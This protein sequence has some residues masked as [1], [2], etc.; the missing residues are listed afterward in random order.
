MLFDMKP[1]V[2]GVIALMAAI[3]FSAQAGAQ[4]Y[5]SATSSERPMVC[6][7]AGQ[8]YDHWVTIHELMGMPDR[9]ATI[10]YRVKLDPSEVALPYEKFQ[11][12]DDIMLV[13]QF[14]EEVDG[15]G[16]LPDILAGRFDESLRRLFELMRERGQPVALRIGP[17]ANSYWK[18]V[19][20]YRGQNRPWMY[21]EAFAKIGELFLEVAGPEMLRFVDWN[22]NQTSF[23]MDSDGRIT[24]LGTSDYEELY[25]RK[26]CER[27]K[28]IEKF[29]TGSNPAY[30][31][32]GTSPDHR[33]V[34]TFA[35]KVGAS[36][37][38][39]GEL[40]LD[41]AVAELGAAGILT[42]K[43]AWFADAIRYPGLVEVHFL[44]E[45]KRV[46]EVSNTIPVSWCFED[47]DRNLDYEGAA[48]FRKMIGEWLAEWGEVR[49]QDRTELLPVE[50]HLDRHRLAAADTALTSGLE[51]PYFAQGVLEWIPEGERNTGINSETGN[52]FGDEEGRIRIIARQ[53]MVTRLDDRTTCG[54]FLN[55]S[56]VGSPNQERYWDNNAR[57]GVD[58]V[59]C[60]VSNQFGFADYGGFFASVGVDHTRYF[61]EDKTP[62]RLDGGETRVIVRAGVQFG[63]K[64]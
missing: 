30:E 46:G 9:C 64:W 17:E 10:Y 48:R 59:R 18:T 37:R 42:D 40:G 27:L 34:F 23:S 50:G 14:E 13:L 45:P 20:V 60:D 22:P 7:V 44:C 35:E 26:F 3:G 21:P 24:N 39:L 6:L 51:F 61:N 16:A 25:P 55:L 11:M 32:G 1:F 19:G 52:E 41:P 54:P 12:S 31:R 29:C 4:A 47:I 53:G 15:Q 28:E 36:L 56:V 33:E 8:G 49:P 63:G 38:R 43:V 2:V 57:V 62:D 58:I 5:P